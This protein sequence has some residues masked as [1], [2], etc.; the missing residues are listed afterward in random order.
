MKKVPDEVVKHAVMNHFSKGDYPQCN[1]CGYNDVR[2]LCLDH[3][4]G[5]GGRHRQEDKYNSRGMNLY[6]KLFNDF[7]PIVFDYEVKVDA[8]V[9]NIEIVYTLPASDNP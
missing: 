8:I 1:N 2:A 3:I 9:R 5:D 7:D 4:N 6:R